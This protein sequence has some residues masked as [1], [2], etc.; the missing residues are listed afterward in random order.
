MCWHT[1]LI[2]NVVSVLSF[3]VF[4]IQN[5]NL[6][7]IFPNY[8]IAR[9]NL[10]TC[11]L[12]LSMVN[13]IITWS[14]IVKLLNT[15]NMQHLP[16]RSVP[17]MGNIDGNAKVS[18]RNI[19]FPAEVD[20]HPTVVLSDPHSSRIWSSHPAPERG[21]LFLDISCICLYPPDRWLV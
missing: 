20:V 14:C 5:N 16:R 13:A 3:S 21:E 4:F 18:L 15:S 11:I 1:D 10:H 6:P 12:K 19:P 17:W 9:E 7:E 2:Q 8:V